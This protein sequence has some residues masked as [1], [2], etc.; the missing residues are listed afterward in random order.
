MRWRRCIDAG[1][2]EGRGL[3]ALKQLVEG[4]RL[5]PDDPAGTRVELD[6]QGEARRVEWL[7]VVEIVG[8]RRSH[9]DEACGNQR[10]VCRL[11][12]RDQKVE[13]AVWAKSGVG[14]AHGEF[15]PLEDDDHSVVCR[16]RLR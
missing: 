6:S 9:G 4:R 15:R 5:R 11:G 2:T 1:G 12:V 8:R 3:G 13:V 7:D 10:S 16:A 14:V